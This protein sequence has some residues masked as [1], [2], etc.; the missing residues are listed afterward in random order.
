MVALY[1]NVVAQY[2]DMVAQYRDMVAQYGD[3]VAQ[4]GDMV[5][6]HGNVVAQRTE[7]L[8]ANVVPGSNLGLVAYCSPVTPLLVGKIILM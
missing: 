6:Q 8:I 1:G 2:G 3:M 5:A 7:R 4:Y